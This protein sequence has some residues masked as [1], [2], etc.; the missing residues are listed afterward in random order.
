MYT[1]PRKTWEVRLRIHFLWVRVLY[2]KKVFVLSNFFANLSIRKTSLS[3][4]GKN[5]IF[6]FIEIVLYIFVI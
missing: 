1:F 5:E 2:E 6:L 3:L 4:A